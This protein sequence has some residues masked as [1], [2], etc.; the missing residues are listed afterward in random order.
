[1]YPHKNYLLFIFIFLNFYIIEA[2][3]TENND[4]YSFKSNTHFVF[5]TEE[6]SVK[7][8]SREI[9]LNA[10]NNTIIQSKTQEVYCG[11]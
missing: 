9:N 5:K 3:N 8:N 1:M 10:P 11:A 7:T 2:K 6:T 4:T